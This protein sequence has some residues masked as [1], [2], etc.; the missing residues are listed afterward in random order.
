MPGPPIS[1]RRRKILYGLA[2]GR[3]VLVESKR[4]V[5]LWAKSR[6]AE[7]IMMITDLPC[8]VPT[9]GDPYTV[10]SLGA[11][12]TSDVDPLGG[13]APGGGSK[14][15]SYDRGIDIKLSDTVQRPRLEWVPARAVVVTAVAGRMLSGRR[16][17]LPLSAQVSKQTAVRYLS[18]MAP[19]SPRKELKSAPG[20]LCGAIPPRS[21]DQLR[22]HPVVPQVRPMLAAVGDRAAID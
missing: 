11:I 2:N 22:R 6:I 20:R 17:L 10:D 7:V 19:Y 16:C 9:S 12:P 21:T 15:N 4:Q 3:Q 1:D 8:A 5:A 14:M 18:K 13:L